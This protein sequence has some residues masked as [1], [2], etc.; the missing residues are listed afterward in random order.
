MS[1]ILSFD[2]GIKNLSYCLMETKQK[3][4]TQDFHNNIERF[5]KEIHIIDWNVIDLST[6]NLSINKNNNPIICNQ[7][8]KNKKCCKSKAT[9]KKDNQ[10]YCN[11]HS[12]NDDLIKEKDIIKLRKQYNKTPIKELKDIFNDHNTKHKKSEIIDVLL[13][14]YTPHI[15]TMVDS[16][17]KKPNISNLSLITIGKNMNEKFNGLFEKYIDSI[18]YVIIENQIGPLAIRMKTIQGMMAQ[19]FIMKNIN[20]I[21]F[22]SSSNKLKLFELGKITYKERKSLGI[23]IIKKYVL[24]NVDL[25]I[26]C[27]TFNKHSKKDDLADAFLQ[28]LYFFYN[29]N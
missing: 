18:D 9:Y 21:E 27:D 5:V 10:L 13:S 23:D 14:K 17:A 2:V 6:D 16:P 15:I 19:Y 7:I 22:I 12:K 8:N 24:N 29:I 28:G 20:K 1:R 25:G 3:I 11:K 26:W 4:N